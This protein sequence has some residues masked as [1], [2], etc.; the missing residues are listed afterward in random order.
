MR[1]LFAVSAL[2]LCGGLA[3][4]AA[5]QP[6][7]PSEGAASEAPQAGPSAHPAAGAPAQAPYH[8][9][10]QPATMFSRPDST[11]P[12]LE[13]DFREPL[14]LL[15]DGPRWSR[16]RTD[17]GAEGYVR[18]HAISNVWVRVSKR[19]QR[20][21]LYEGTRRVVAAPADFG[22]NAFLDKKRRGS[23]LRRDDWRTPEG[24]LYIVRKNPHSRFDRALVLNYPTAADAARGLENG[25][26]TPRE[27]RQIVEAQEELAPPPMDTPLGGMI[28]IHGD[29][30]GE[31]RNWTRGCVALHNRDLSKIWNR[32]EV[33]T[34]VVI[35]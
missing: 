18:S 34:P 32:V 29:G 3:V 28:E 4:P 2:L 6:A 9:I 11:D 35:E 20:A 1:A 10:G 23:Q 15:E 30:T 5:A 8:V 16:V 33:G 21:Y 17:G 14:H 22:P 19:A 26:I 25:L 12:Y 24:T 27:H 7:T 31:A 13:I